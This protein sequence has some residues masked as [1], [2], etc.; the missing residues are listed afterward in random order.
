MSTFHQ[1]LGKGGAGDGP[2]PGREPRSDPR[3]DMRRAALLSCYYH[4]RT[5]GEDH[6]AA[7]MHLRPLSLEQSVRYLAEE[8]PAPRL[9]QHAAAWLLESERPRTDEHAERLLGAR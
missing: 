9:Q 6:R 4:S 1:S 5:D 7:P 2:S 8:D 3:R